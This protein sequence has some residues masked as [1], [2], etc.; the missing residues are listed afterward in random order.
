MNLDSE[1][2][3]LHDHMLLPD[4]SGG[5]QTTLS[6]LTPSL[7]TFIVFFGRYPSSCCFRDWILSPSSGKNLLSRAQSTELVPISLAQAFT[8]SV[9]TSPPEQWPKYQVDSVSPHEKNNKKY[10]LTEAFIY[11]VN[12]SLSP[13]IK[14]LATEQILTNSLTQA[15]IYTVNTSLTPWIWSLFP[16]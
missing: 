5:H 15:F 1:P 16:Q 11:T 12:M 10:P 2:H 6:S 13:C 3:G 14:L 4:G 8:Y 9:N 7:S